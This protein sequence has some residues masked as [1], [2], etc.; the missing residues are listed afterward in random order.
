MNDNSKNPNGSTNAGKNTSS[1]KGGGPKSPEGKVRSSQ[2]ALKLG[3]FARRTV[4]A[5]EDPA[6]FQSFRACLL[7]DLKPRGMIQ[8]CL[9]EEIVNLFWRLLRTHRAEQQI[10]D[11]YAQAMNGEDQ[12]VGFAI[13]ADIEERNVLGAIGNA[14]LRLHGQLRRLIKTFHEEQRRD[15]ETLSV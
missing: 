15:A 8:E 12:G 5:S 4:L 11:R 10:I 1:K 2:N 14:E 9:A 13:L 6:E 3:L 7:D